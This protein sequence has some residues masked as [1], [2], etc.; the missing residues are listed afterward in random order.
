MDDTHPS[1][2]RPSLRTGRHSET[3]RLHL[4]TAVTFQRHPLFADW[5]CAWAA[6]ASL[7]NPPT[8]PQAELLCWVLM[9]AH[10]HG[11]LRIGEG[12][13]LA[14]SVR[15]AKACAAR[16]ANLARGRAGLVWEPGF[17]DR[18]LRKEGDLVAAARYIVQNPVR[19]GLARRPAEYPY[20][21][22]MWLGAAP[23]AQRGRTLDRWTASPALP[24][25]GAPASAGSLVP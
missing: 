10:W 18:P 19:A 1:R 24:S 11:L 7:A 16:A 23:R 22:A 13:D 5:R 17:H 20:W 4:I 9:P 3:G 21:D 2:G 15:A 14:A 8:W 25:S 6:S 12:T